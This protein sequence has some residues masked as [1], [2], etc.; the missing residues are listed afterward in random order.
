MQARRTTRQQAFTLVELLVVIGII[1]VLI[2]ILLPALSRARMQAKKVACMSNLRQIGQA[3]QMYT[4]AHKGVLPI[5]D[6][7]GA[8]YNDAGV[9]IAGPTADRATRWNL[10]VKHTLNPRLDPT[11]NG[12][13]QTGGD[14]N[15]LQE[16]FQC[17]EAPGEN[18][19][20]QNLSSTISYMCHPILMPGLDDTSNRNKFPSTT[21]FT[22]PYKIS[23]IRR[24]SEIALVF[25]ATMVYE[26]GVWHTYQ[27]SSVAGFIDNGGWW[28]APYLFDKF[29][30]GTAGTANPD[31]SIDMTCMNQPLNKFVNQDVFR[32]PRN[33][34]FRHSRDTVANALMVD[35]HVENF[36]YDPKKSS[37]DKT[38]TNFKRRNL[39]VNRP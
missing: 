31:D 12:S 3:I 28:R 1:A 23:K 9:M 19:T 15:K 17:P 18:N 7:E 36:T 20:K 5:G 29:G 6:W 30:D 16:L 35:G 2:G 39:Y 10:L 27:E 32:N 25:D 4:V 38:V 26:N 21:L 14:T 13:A 34:R 22:Q 37:N 8:A 24:S 11:W 33:V